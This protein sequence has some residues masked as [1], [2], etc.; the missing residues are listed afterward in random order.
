MKSGITE[1][2][3][4]LQRNIVPDF[5]EDS[6]SPRKFFTEFIYVE[7]PRQMLINKT[8][9]NLTYLTLLILLMTVNVM[10]AMYKNCYHV[11]I[12]NSILK[13]LL[14]CFKVLRGSFLCCT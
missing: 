1:T 12:V 9:K 7:F 2:D 13:K 8:P 3:L 14:Y 4:G 6:S 10:V 5:I 11:F